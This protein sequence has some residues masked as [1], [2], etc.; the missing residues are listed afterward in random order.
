MYVYSIQNSGIRRR[1]LGDGSF[2]QVFPGAA[3]S[4]ILKNLGRSVWVWLGGGP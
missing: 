1:A 4:R 3:R 2:E